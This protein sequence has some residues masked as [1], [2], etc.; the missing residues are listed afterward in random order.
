MTMHAPDWNLYRSFL[1]VMR[2]GSLSAAAR[3][4]G[5]TQP[6]MGRHIDALEAALARPLFTR[7]S[8]GLRPTAYAQQLLGPAQAM[9]SAAQEAARLTSGQQAQSRG[10]VRISASQII[11]GE[12]LPELL[13]RFQAQH[14]LMAIE[15]VLNNQQDDLLKREA[16]IAV[17]MVRPTQK[18][19]MAKRLGRVD[20]GMY[21]HQ[22]YIMRR[23]MPHSMMDLAQHTLIGADTDPTAIHLAQQV[24]LH[25]TREDFQFRCDSDLA[26]LAALRAGLGIGG[27]QIG[28]AQRDPQLVP[29]Q[30]DVLTF[31]LDMWLITHGDL[32]RDPNVMTLYRHLATHLTA[33]A[34]TSQRAK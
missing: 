13:A 24:G 34:L 18:A 30:P 26:Q 25:I 23:G 17:R 3:S 14:P 21:A 4:L 33:Y 28:I 1:A 32:R 27:C 6:S 19:L 9:A 11:G 31:S 5:M 20:I 2:E 15:L 7:S 22:R 8:E 10:T 29:V 12:V 16:D